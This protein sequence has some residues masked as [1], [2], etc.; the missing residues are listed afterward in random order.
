MLS[1]DLVLRFFVFFFLESLSDVMFRP[2]VQ[3]KRVAKGCSSSLPNSEWTCPRLGQARLTW[4]YF[5]Q[6]LGPGVKNIQR[7]GWSIKHGND[8]GLHQRVHNRGTRGCTSWCN[9]EL[10]LFWTLRHGMGD[11]GADIYEL[12]AGIT[13]W[14]DFPI[15]DFSLQNCIGCNIEGLVI[16]GI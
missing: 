15:S 13:C 11:G 16:F 6:K 8:A 14:R 7:A 12:R 5:I 3:C 1:K 9:C 4:I 10:L 2:L